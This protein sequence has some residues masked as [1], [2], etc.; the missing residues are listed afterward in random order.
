MCN[1][2]KSAGDLSGG[3]GDAS[4]KFPEIDD[5]R[6]VARL[7]ARRADGGSLEGGRG[8]P[9]SNTVPKSYNPVDV[10]VL[11]VGVDSLYVS[12]EGEISPS[13][14]YDLLD[15]KYLAQSRDSAERAKAQWPIKG[16]IFE[17]SDK[18]QRGF[19]YVIEDN[20]YRIC[21]RS[22]NSYSLPLA[23]VKI[24][25]EVLSHKGVEVAV[26]ELLEIIS[27]IGET[28]AYPNISRVDLYADFQTNVDLEMFTRKD[29]VT[30][31]GSINSYSC[32]GRF[33]GW[34]VGMGGPIVMRLYD[35][36]L[37][38]VRSHKTYLFEMWER[39]GLNPDI[40]V[41]RLEFQFNRQVLSQ[42]GI[43]SYE[44]MLRSYGGMWGYASQTWLKLTESQ[45]DD[46]NRA[47]WPIHP[48]WERLAD[49]K[50][51]LDDYPLTRNYSNARVPSV[52]K[53]LRLHMSLLTS[54]MAVKRISEYTEGIKAFIDKCEELHRQRCRE[55]LEVGFEEWVAIE[56][57]SKGR[58]FNT[59][60]N[61]PSPE[62]EITL[63][64]EE[65]RVAIAYH[66]ASRGE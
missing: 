47:R 62:E 9:P 48:L 29:W 12:F 42:L 3:S 64:D 40:P 24:S 36:T 65:A 56:V 59:L 35:K 27:E 44:S 1:R 53:L 28:N 7:G 4:S 19:A 45:I 26:D 25:S 20:A 43:S 63:S 10:R 52:D 6:T 57:S 46:T 49:I 66:Q 39:G 8:T 58:K 21:I 41:W 37:E 32:Y 50:W 15:C 17:V 34:A 54:F 23:W 5:D 22:G 38:L 16:H 2:N 31:A 11:R 60:L 61:I 51:R 33:S 14:N 55:Y 30:R 13:V 18:G